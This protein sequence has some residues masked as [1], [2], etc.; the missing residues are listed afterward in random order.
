MTHNRPIYNDIWTV[1][2]IIAA[3]GLG[4][5]LCDIATGNGPRLANVL[6]AIFFAL[7][8]TARGMSVNRRDWRL[9]CVAGLCSAAITALALVLAYAPG[10]TAAV[11]EQSGS[12]LLL[13]IWLLMI[14]VVYR[15]IL[16]GQLR[17]QA[18]REKE[19]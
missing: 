11:R 12:Y 10:T 6:F 15:E 3:I 4:I 1:T 16:L 7:S 19:N 2:G 8:T 9:P 14:D 18:A 13:G 17:K 5:A